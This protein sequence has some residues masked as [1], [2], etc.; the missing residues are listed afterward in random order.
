MENAIVSEGA[1]GPDVATRIAAATAARRRRPD[2]AVEVRT[3][4]DAA[5][6]VIS[7]TERA[8]VA[9]IVAEAGLSND[10]FYRHFPSKHALVAALPEDGAQRLASYLQHQTA[11]ERS[12]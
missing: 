4:L 1:A 11:K 5:R 7:R 12:A 3:L 9:D 2:Y 8:R 10:A 6:K